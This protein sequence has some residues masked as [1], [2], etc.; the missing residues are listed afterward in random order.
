MCL[1]NTFLHL[2]ESVWRESHL[3]NSCGTIVSEYIGMQMMFSDHILIE[4]ACISD[5]A[6]HFTI[7][8]KLNFLRV[9]N[10]H[11]LWF[12][13]RSHESQGICEYPADNSSINEGMLSYQTC[14]SI[15][16]NNKLKSLVKPSVGSFI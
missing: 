7:N 13:G 11:F 8:F 3:L 4:S 9:L 6:F 1:K 16:K 12:L 10:G 14:S 5:V 2:D 15:L